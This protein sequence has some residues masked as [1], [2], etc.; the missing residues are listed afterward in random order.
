MTKKFAFSAIALLTAVSPFLSVNAGNGD[1]NAAVATAA[2]NYGD[3]RVE[4]LAFADDAIGPFNLGPF[5]VVAEPVDSCKPNDCDLYDLRLLRDGRTFLVPNVPGAAL[6]AQ[7]FAVND[8]RL[9]FASQIDWNGD[10]Y[11]VTEYDA[12]GSSQ[13]LVED[14]FFSGV[15]AIDAMADGDDTYFTV[16]HDYTGK[17]RVEQAGV[18]VY[19]EAEGDAD[20]I[21]PHWEL[22]EETLLDAADG[23]AL[24]KLA[25]ESGHKQLWLGDTHSVNYSGMTRRA[26]AGTWVEPGADM[27][28]AHF[29]DDDTVEF[30]MNFVRHTYDLD[31]D[32]LTRFDGEHL[33]WFRDA[34]VSYQVVGDLMAWVDPSDALYLS[35]DGVAERI[36]TATDGQFLLEED[37][38][39]Y[40]V[41]D[42]GRVYDIRTGRTES[43]PFAVTD[44]DGGDALVGLDGRGRVQYL[45]LATGRSYELGFGSAPVLSDDMHAYWMGVD[46]SI[47]E[48]TVALPSS[49]SAGHVRAMKTAN[50]DTV[51]LVLNGEKRAVP[52]E[53]TYFTWFSSW[54]DVETVSAS[55]L[56]AYED[57]GT[58][59][60]APGTKAKIANDPKVYIVGNDGRLHWIV[61]QTAAFTIFGSTWNQGILTITQQ[62]LVTNPFGSPV[63]TERDLQ[64]V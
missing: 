34:S 4:R 38:L 62:D 46:G 25:F 52:S 2:W 41:G 5:A 59:A 44:T 53:K 28:A 23:V 48:G 37:R 20:I 50:D 60:F 43:V 6:D 12:D 40:A 49:A 24:V 11:A 15:E 29:V 3:Y 17:T 36:G 47:Y 39:F 57:G 63:E 18:Y 35:K 54:D 31:D 19:D 27:Y 14:V 22:R 9:V 64:S 56:A 13:K 32:T 21:G 16:A 30:F 58:A 7:R 51:Y 55:T 26:I 42:E 61:S 8:G 1:W 45:D 10:H 33:N